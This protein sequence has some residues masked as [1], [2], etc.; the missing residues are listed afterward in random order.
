MKRK[1]MKRKNETAQMIG[2]IIRPN[3]YPAIKTHHSVESCQQPLSQITLSQALEP[4]SGQVVEFSTNNVPH[5]RIT[6]LLGQEIGKRIFLATEEHTCSQVVIKLLLFC[7]DIE[8]DSLQ[9]QSSTSA[10][11]P[12]V[13]LPYLSSFEVN[14]PLGEGII[15]VKPCTDAQ[16]LATDQS[17]PLQPRSH[18]H[19]QTH[20]RRGFSSNQPSLR[21]TTTT[22]PT[23]TPRYTY[24]KL[25]VR[26]TRQKLEIQLPESYVREGL[27]AY[28]TSGPMLT[29]QVEMWLIVVLCTVVF[30]GGTVA[31][32][33]SILAGIIVAALLPL[34]YRAIARPPA[35][36]RRVAKIRITNEPDGRTFLSLTSTKAPTRGFSTESQR[37]RYGHINSAPVE[38]KLHGARLSIKAVKVSPTIILTSDLN[39]IKAQLSFSLHNQNW[40]SQNLR[41]VGTYAEIRWLSHHLSQWGR[42]RDTHSPSI[43]IDQGK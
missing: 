1:D 3:I 20:Q 5:Y 15:L 37:D 24:S 17:V 18:Q 35:T 29:K 11:E 28:D 26:V 30:V 8:E 33:G 12:A 41:I 27:V 19:Q 43:R 36:N 39:P 22:N 40:H 13:N 14:T 7:P 38:S 34:L 2:H 10:Y 31:S 25:K 16:L 4:G 32:T 9:Q 6:R 42:T 21:R 23:H